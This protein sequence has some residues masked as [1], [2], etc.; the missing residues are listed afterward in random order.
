MTKTSANRTAVADPALVRRLERAIRFG[1]D[2]AGARTAAV[3]TAALSALLDELRPADEFD[4]AM[5]EDHGAAVARALHPLM[6]HLM[7]DSSD[8]VDSGDPLA[9]GV[10]AADGALAAA[11]AAAQIQ[12]A[13]GVAGRLDHLRREHG[14]ADA[15]AFKAA[16]AAYENADGW[17]GVLDAYPDLPAILDAFAGLG[18]GEC[19]TLDL[20]A[21]PVPVVLHR[22]ATGVGFDYDD[23]DYDADDGDPDDGDDD[24]W[25]DDED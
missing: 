3:D 24:D 21:A 13:V 15:E 1:R 9:D 8:A 25:D 11:H 4:P 12:I 7:A 18:V 5:A 16:F 20:E 23:P 6:A 10:A 19:A 17:D 2:K 22:T 14:E